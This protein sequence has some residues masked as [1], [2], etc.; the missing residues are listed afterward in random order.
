M[1][2]E[3]SAKV[4]PAGSAVTALSCPSVWMIVKNPRSEMSTGATGHA[5]E[6][7][8]S[9]PSE[10]EN[11]YLA[12]MRGEISAVAQHVM[13]GGR[14]HPDPELLGRAER[15]DLHLRHE[16]GG[17]RV[18]VLELLLEMA[19]Q[20]QHR[21][22]EFALAVAECALAIFVDHRDG[23]EHDGRDEQGAAY[24]QPRDRVAAMRHGKTPRA[25]R[26]V[27]VDCASDNGNQF[28]HSLSP[29]GHA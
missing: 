28:A 25:R 18:V 23:A 8:I 13:H 19:A 10:I 24:D 26:R 27:T 6:E 20:Q 4:P 22:F 11:A 7:L 29:E 2:V 12:D 17:D 9:R 16:V 1:R 21:I 14:G 3:V 5:V 15:S